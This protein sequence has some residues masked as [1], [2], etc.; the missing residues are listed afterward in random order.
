VSGVCSDNIWNLR[1]SDLAGVEF[2]ALQLAGRRIVSQ[3]REVGSVAQA[4]EV[5]LLDVLDLANLDRAA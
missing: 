5:E 2:L 3:R 1:T 4:V